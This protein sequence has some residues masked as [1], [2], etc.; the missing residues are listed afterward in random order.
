M[1]PTAGLWATVALIC[2]TAL[3]RPAEDAMNANL[4]LS[5]RYIEL[6]LHAMDG[7]PATSIERRAGPPGED[8][9]REGTDP[10]ACCFGH[11]A[12]PCKCSLARFPQTTVPHAESR[13][14]KY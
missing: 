13:R 2:A 4:D 5:P 7:P 3:A 9:T 1:A 12:V 10:D 14:G 8:I 6:P 11:Y